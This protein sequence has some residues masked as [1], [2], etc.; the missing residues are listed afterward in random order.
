[1]LRLVFDTAA[2]RRSAVRPACEFGRRL[3]A[4]WSGMRRHAPRRCW[5]PQPGTAVLRW[6]GCI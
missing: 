4:S 5:N 2:L 3:A 1:M 6:R